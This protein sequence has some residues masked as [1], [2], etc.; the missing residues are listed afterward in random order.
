[1]TKPRVAALKREGRIVLLSDGSLDPNSVAEL[2][3]VLAARKG[4]PVT[5]VPRKPEPES[6][7]PLPVVDPDVDPSVVG[8][9]GLPGDWSKIGTPEAIRRKEVAAA[10]RG[11]LTAAQEAGSLVRAEEVDREW[12]RVLGFV[13]E[14]V[15]ALPGRAA[16]RMGLTDAQQR[17]LEDLVHEALAAI[18]ADE[19]LDDSGAEKACAGCSGAAS[20]ADAQ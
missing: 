4:N 15:L 6:A 13:R 2:G 18:S 14:S 10:Y 7:A 12:A 9:D 20:Q 3:E 19:D 8:V 1:M 11:T 17:G 5:P 16:S